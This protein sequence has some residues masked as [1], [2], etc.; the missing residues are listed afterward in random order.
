MNIEKYIA[1][2][3]QEV[4]LAWVDGTKRTYPA[5]KALALCQVPRTAACIMGAECG[6]M[7]LEAMLNKLLDNE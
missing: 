2:H 6:D 4:T 7:N 1:Q 3:P 5:K